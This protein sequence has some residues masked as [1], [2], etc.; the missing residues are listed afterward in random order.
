M[1][2]DLYLSRLDYTGPLAPN[3]ET[4][5]GLH[6]AHL[7]CVPFENLDIHLGRVIRLD[8]E[9]LF[10]KIV[11]RRRG[12][13]CFELNGLFAWL[14][15]SLGFQVDLLSAASAN[16][17]GTFLAD[18]EHMALRVICPDNPGQAWLA[19]VGWGNGFLEPLRLEPGLLQ[20]QS[21]RVYRL[22]PQEERLIFAEQQESGR[23]LWHYRFSL[24]PHSLEEFD[25][26][27]AYMQ[28]SPDSLFT[29]KRL[30]TRFTPD[31]RITLSNLKLITTTEAGGLREERMLSGEE[32]ARVVLKDLF[33]INL[34]V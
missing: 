20:R 15:E 17:D 27:C 8:R 22:E 16:D 5:R 9:A 18:F 26:M 33:G 11:T 7:Y 23:W 29:Q 13:F 6:R 21:E 30:C 28:S 2:T 34:M 4:L 24:Q 32:E 3:A 10:E 19:D 25:E 1:R 31:G 14:L 12:G